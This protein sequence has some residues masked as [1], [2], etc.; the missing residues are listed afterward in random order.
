[1]LLLLGANSSSLLGQPVYGQYDINTQRSL[2]KRATAYLCHEER[3]SLGNTR[4][5]VH[6][7]HEIVPSYRTSSGRRIKRKVWEVINHEKV[8]RVYHRCDVS[9]N[10]PAVGKFRDGDGYI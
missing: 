5:V 3:L 10:L 9:V 2:I 6:V 1:M 8:D 4:I 7:G